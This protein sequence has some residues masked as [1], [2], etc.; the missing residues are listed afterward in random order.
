MSH[1]VLINGTAYT[2]AGGDTLVSGTKYQLGGG[3]TLING[4]AY[5][6]PFG[7]KTVAITI[8]K[9]GSMLGH[10]AYVLYNGQQ[11]TSG[12]INVPAGESVMVHATS[13]QESYLLLNDAYV[14]SGKM[15][16]YTYTPTAGIA[17]ATINIT[18]ESSQ[19]WISINES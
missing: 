14:E 7:P 13:H 6:V 18:V 8:T 9:T 5:D 16:N 12:T 19:W 2:V 10:D 17:A 15:L 4:A 11:Y 3:K 1:K